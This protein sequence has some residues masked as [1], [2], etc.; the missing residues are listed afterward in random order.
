MARKLSAKDLT[1]LREAR[2]SL[3]TSM[4]AAGFDS[5]IRLLAALAASMFLAAMTTR[6]PRSAR[7][8]EVSSPMPLAPPAPAALRRVIAGDNGCRRR[9]IR[10]GEEEDR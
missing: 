1:D 2:S 10:E 4:R 7:T 8:L 5:I 9:K 3:R 6:A